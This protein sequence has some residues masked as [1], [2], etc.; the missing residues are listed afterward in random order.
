MPATLLGLMV[1]KPEENELFMKGS[2]SVAR[3][4]IT[5]NLC[6]VDKTMKETLMR[7]AS[8]AA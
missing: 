2:I 8:Y 7:Y 4:L 5:G 3:S 1:T 6:A